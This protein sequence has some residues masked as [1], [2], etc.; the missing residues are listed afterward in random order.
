MRPFF[1]GRPMKGPGQKDT[2]RRRGAELRGKREKNLVA[3]S[4]KLTLHLGFVLTL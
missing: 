3:T 2:Q 1:L 4:V